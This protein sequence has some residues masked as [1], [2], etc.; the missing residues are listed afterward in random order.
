MIDKSRDVDKASTEMAKLD[1]SA[2]KQCL[3]NCSP[4][5][6]MSGKDLGQEWNRE[7]GWFEMNSLTMGQVKASLAPWAV[8][9]V[10][11]EW[12]EVHA[13]GRLVWCYWYS[14]IFNNVYALTHV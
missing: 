13:E 12:V 14:T 7:R 4:P 1:I 3:T 10:S 9:A 2:Q 5:S 6:H 8:L 11:H